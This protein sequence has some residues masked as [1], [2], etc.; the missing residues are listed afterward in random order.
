MKENISFVAH[1]PSFKGDET[2]LLLV[3][4][5]TIAWLSSRFAELARTPIESKNASFVIGDGKPI[6]SD[7][8]CTVFVELN[9]EASGSELVAESPTTFSWILSAGSASHYVDLLSEM[10]KATVPCHQYLDPDNCP[11]APV[12]MVSLEEYEADDFRHRKVQS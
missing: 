2:L 7:G 6:Q 9:H 12:V 10:V 5:E 4:H 11:P 3:D 1:L 8:Q